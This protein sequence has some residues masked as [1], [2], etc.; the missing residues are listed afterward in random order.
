MNSK[1][2]LASDYWSE[3][4]PDTVLDVIRNDCLQV[5]EFKKVKALVRWRKAQ[6]NGDA[7]DGSNVWCNIEQCLKFI[8]FSDLGHQEFAQLRDSLSDLHK[9]LS[10]EEKCC[11]FEYICQGDEIQL[12]LGTGAHTKK[13]HLAL[14]L[15]YTFQ[16]NLQTQGNPLKFCMEFE[17]DKCVQFVGLQY[18]LPQNCDASFIVK[19]NF[20]SFGFLVQKEGSQIVAGGTSADKLESKGSEF[21]R[22]SPKCLLERNTKYSIEF[23]LPKVL[24]NTYYQSYLLSSDENPVTDK[25]LTLK[26][27]SNTI[28][29][30]VTQLLFKLA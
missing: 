25:D 18:L 15:P 21:F 10:A 19:D 23:I 22:V 24:Q 27:L 16:Q 28:S 9:V 11:I 7:E 8:R 17:V 5:S 30:N 1:K 13:V 12:L 3:A 20:D 2:A 14:D 6:G 29:A 4:S 26:L